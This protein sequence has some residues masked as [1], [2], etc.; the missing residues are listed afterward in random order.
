MIGEDFLLIQSIEL[1]ITKEAK[2]QQHSSV[3]AELGCARLGRKAWTFSDLPF[4]W[5]KE[6]HS[7][8]H[9]SVLLMVILRSC[10]YNKFGK[11][12]DCFAAIYFIS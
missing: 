2:S 5:S 9:C 12:F 7:H 3:F 11:S 6:T 4:H 1:E 8:P 10:C